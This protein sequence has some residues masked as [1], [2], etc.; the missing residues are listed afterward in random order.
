[1]SLTI[2]NLSKFF[3]SHQA[4]KN[5]SFVVEKGTVFGLLG[6]NGAGKST[7]IK[8]ILGLLDIS[9][10][11]IEWEGAPI[12]P[13]R[14]SIG[15][16]PEERGLF[17]KR[18]VYEQLVYFGQ[19]ENMKK[20]EINKTIDVWL[21]RMEIME[22]KNKIVSVL[23]KGNQQKIQLIAAL[24]HNP[25]LIILD[26]PFTGLDPVNVQMFMDIIKDEAAK[27]KTI[28]FSSHQMAIVE[29][30]CD[31]LILLKKG[32]AE[33]E[34]TIKSIKDSYGY[35]NLVFDNFDCDE[36][37]AKEL[38]KLELDYVQDKNKLIVKIEEDSKALEIL[39]HLESSGVT[40]PAFQ[41]APPT[42]QEIFVERI[43]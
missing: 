12:K 41:L 3:G 2:N 9:E 26:E 38:S 8:Q 14:I 4:V 31:E 13:E 17:T 43:G 40:I 16:L 39:N 6:R 10:G 7:T 5:L 20:D 36:A 37:I 34:G 32:E 11:S 22:N 30:L 23:S 15:Y 21:E 35:K 29:E 24:L 25:E 28:I 27:G 42:M 18:S 1:M 19:L 33:V